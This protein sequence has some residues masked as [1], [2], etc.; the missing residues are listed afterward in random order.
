MFCLSAHDIAQLTGGRILCGSEELQADNVVIDSREAAPGALFAAF[1][2]A[3]VDGHDFLDAA[4]CGGARI[5]LISDLSRADDLME[6]A[7]RSGAA[8]IHVADVQAALWDLARANRARLHIPVIAITGSS[9]KTSTKELLTAVLAQRMKVVA[10]YA[11]Y[12]NELGVPLTILRAGKDTEALVVEMGMRAAGEIAALAELAAPQIGIITNIGLAHIETLGS[13]RAI[14]AAKAELLAAL[15]QDGLAIYPDD[16]G[17]TELLR[18]ATACAR[19]LTCS[20]DDPAADY[21]A[22]GLES[23]AQACFT[24]T[25]HTPRSQLRVRLQVPGRHMMAN[26]LLCIAAGE[27]L[28]LCDDDIAQGLAGAQTVG[29][30][31]AS[32]DVASRGIRILADAYN[33]NPD[34]MAAAL[35]TLSALRPP[36]PQGRRVAVLGDMLELGDAAPAAHRALLELAGELGLGYLFVFGSQFCA[37]APPEVAYDDMV[38]L[39]QAL[40]AFLRPGDVVL[41]K[42][43]RGMR[44]E[45]VIEALQA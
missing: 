16:T 31:L 33:A 27:E 41:V 15:P 24:A 38:V 26:A 20:M 28:G 2:G 42:G 37:V 25:V 35:R 14:A 19:T 9:G 10:T 32:I 6:Q 18:E 40:C 43:S 1:A 21:Y 23:D 17:Y 29:L 4:F 39:T 34:S 3:S 12:N 5:A 36:L 30:R 13:P 44:M 11:N 22:S 8:L 45:R 7:Q